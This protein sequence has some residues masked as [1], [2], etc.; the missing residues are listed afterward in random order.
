MRGKLFDE[1]YDPSQEL[2]REPRAF[3]YELATQFIKQAKDNP[4]KD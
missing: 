2:P 4:A 3:G 1:F